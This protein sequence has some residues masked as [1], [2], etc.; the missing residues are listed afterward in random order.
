VVELAK[1][2]GLSLIDDSE[3]SQAAL[4]TKLDA[5]KA[6]LGG[7]STTPTPNNPHNPGPQAT[8][9][10]ELV[11]REN[12]WEG[13]PMALASAKGDETVIKKYIRDLPAIQR[14]KEI[15]QNGA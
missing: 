6:Q 14:M 10:E 3:A 9:R 15:A 5:F 13:S 8:N 2:A 1:T 7:A 12:V 11:K 4:K